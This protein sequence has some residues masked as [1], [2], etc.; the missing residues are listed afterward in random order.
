MPVV[1]GSPNPRYKGLA[2]RLRKTRKGAGLT[3]MALAQ[4]A[5]VSEA[6]V[7]YIELEQRIPT[8]ATVARLAAALD[9]SAAWLT[10][11]LGEPKDASAI[12]S[13]D[14]MGQRLQT[15]RT[16]RT[17]TRTDLARLAVLN[18]GSIAKIEGG[19]QAGVDTVEQLAKALRISQAWLAYGIGPRELAP[20]RRSTV[21]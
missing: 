7:L 10:Y 13:C 16:D 14:G 17:Q 5:R 8:V 6:T 12:A 15:A 20:R 3:R 18:P 21:A 11:G 1:R 4:G 19:G 2:L 9:I